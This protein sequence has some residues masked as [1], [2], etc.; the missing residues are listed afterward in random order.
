MQLYRRILLVFIVCVSFI[1]A[2]SQEK[3]IGQFTHKIVVGLNL[4]A[5][6]PNYLSREIRG[7]DAYWIQFAPQLGY[8]VSYRF[9]D[10]WSAE[11]GIGIDIKGMGVRDRVKY[12]YTDVDMDGSSIKGYFTGRNQ[13]EVKI[14]YITIPLRVAFDLNSTWRLRA[15]GYVSYRSSSEFSGTVW[16]GYLRETANKDIINGNDIEIKE[17]DIA[18]FDFGKEMRDFDFGLSL[19]F[20]HQFNRRF[21]LYTDFT[22][23]LTTVFPSSFTGIDM[24]MRNIYVQVGMSYTLCP[25]LHNRRFYLNIFSIASSSSKEIIVFPSGVCLCVG[26]ANN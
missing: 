2:F 19:G 25:L 16:D 9:A 13:T 11:S 7:I 10:R 8:N 21:G 14:S 26:E 18:T 5:T 22:Y 20:D 1:S 3:T 23:G 15:G 4:G 17:K 6:M 24:K 12:M